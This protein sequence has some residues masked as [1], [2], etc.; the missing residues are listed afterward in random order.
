MST[1][2]G[3]G[4]WK[5]PMQYPLVE[6]VEEDDLH[7]VGRIR[8]RVTWSHVV[9]LTIIKEREQMKKR[10]KWKHPFGCL[11]VVDSYLV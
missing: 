2:K 6:A 10:A 7:S 11:G 5:Y 8:G 3:V 4:L 1:F 9:F